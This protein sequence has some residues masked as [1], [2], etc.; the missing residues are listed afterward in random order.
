MEIMADLIQAYQRISTDT[1][2]S[3]GYEALSLITHD[4]LIAQQV[5]IQTNLGTVYLNRGEYQTADSLFRTAL[6]SA[7]NIKDMKQ[8]A[9]IYNNFGLSQSNQHNYNVAIEY[10]LKSAHLSDSLNIMETSIR[11]LVNIGVIYHYQNNTRASLDYHLK[12]LRKIAQH[13]LD[14]GTMQAV[15]LR[16]TGA[17]YQLLKMMDSAYY[18]TNKSLEISLKNNDKRGLSICYQNLGDFIVEENPKD[19]EP[20]YLKSLALKRELKNFNGIAH[21]TASLGN[22]YLKMKKHH[23]AHGYFSESLQYAEKLGDL[24]LL[25]EIH[26]LL[27]KNYEQLGDIT[28]AL[29]HHKL[30][31]E[32]KDSLVARSNEEKILAL[33]T[34]YET[35]QKEKQILELKHQQNLNEIT[36][37]NNRL[38]IALSF[39]AIAIIGFLFVVVSRAFLSIKKKRDILKEKNAIIELQNEEI[40]TQRDHLSDSNQ[41]IQ[42]QHRQIE[43]S[44]DYARQIQESLLPTRAILSAIFGEHLLFFQPKDVVSGDF[45]WVHQTNRF[46]Y[47]AVGDCTGHGVPGAFMSVLSISLLNEVVK[48][49]GI[50]NPAAILEEMRRLIISSL[51]QDGTKM[52]GTDGLE[53]ALCRIDKD[54][55]RLVFAGAQRSLLL[56]RNEEMEEFSPNKMPVSAHV[57][58][59]EFTDQEFVTQSGDVLYMFTDGFQDQFESQN[60]HRYGKQRLKEFLLTGKHL[61]LSNQ[62]RALE[63]EFSAWKGDGEQIDDVLVLGLRC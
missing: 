8:T 63:T 57:T 26:K 49:N 20:F 12:A 42:E 14:L 5:R 59:T 23:K 33:Q 51:K 37:K 30:Y 45:Y 13:D 22:A 6:H 16:N 19:A 35:S 54:T 7:L 40:R 34:Q 47:V 58:M 41:R 31:V 10:Y 39:F 61:S 53:L 18:Y 62:Q 32:S 50:S 36:I 21:T 60:S 9:I 52:G 56:L 43:D 38:I 3:I 4:S 1:A 2:L 44:I 29:K 15:I 17:F 27:S 24:N 46:T 48:G 11:T 25:V 28:N 55:K